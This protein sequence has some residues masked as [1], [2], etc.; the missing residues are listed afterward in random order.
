MSKTCT[1][2]NLLLMS[3]LCCTLA[4]LCTLFKKLRQISQR[5][6]TT[7]RAPATERTPAQCLPTA[8]SP[9]LSPN[10][11]PDLTTLCEEHSQE[12][13]SHT[14]HSAHGASSH[15]AY[16]TSATPVLE[17]DKT[18]HYVGHYETEYL[19]L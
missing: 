14:C 18:N 7:E 2:M 6:P 16:I 11:A 5:E 9:T 8:K 17:V 10:H 4:C 1:H 12:P 3:Y 15:T 19:H 13:Q